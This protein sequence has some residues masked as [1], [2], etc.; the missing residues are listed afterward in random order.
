MEQRRR[1]R[2]GNPNSKYARNFRL[3][4]DRYRRQPGGERW[5]GT[6]IADA[7]GKGSPGRSY[8]SGV[9]TGAIEKP[10]G[11]PLRKIAQAMGFPNDYWYMEPEDLRAL[12]FGGAGGEADE[13]TQVSDAEPGENATSDDPPLRAGGQGLATLI[14]NQIAWAM[15]R[16]RGP[17]T[18]R[19]VAAATGW[20]LTEK[21]LKKMRRGAWDRL[22]EAE[23]LALSDAFGV[24]P[25]YWHET[26]RKRALLTPGAV[27]AI[28]GDEH[29][30][31]AY[32]ADGWTREARDIIRV[33]SGGRPES[34]ERPEAGGG[35][36]EAS[37]GG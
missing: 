18:E 36:A 22:T 24:E 12:L 7:T 34:S 30:V 19:D 3:L 11:E 5:Q 33:L 8:I 37:N 31:V 9:L 4:L 17:H 25:E 6:Q 26:R 27:E 1:K 16:R 23:Q 29:F 14:D 13:R 28:L 20:R 35:L 32:R 2:V 21:E 15:L 10:G